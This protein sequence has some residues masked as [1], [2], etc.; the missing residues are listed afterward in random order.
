[1]GTNGLTP[2]DSN[3]SVGNNQYVETVN[4]RYQIWSLNRA[5]QHTDLPAGTGLDQHPVGGVRRALP[6]TERGDPSSSMT[7]WRTAGSSRSS[8]PRFPP[9]STTSAW[10]SPPPRTRPGLTSGGP[11]PCRGACSATTRTSGPGRT[12]TT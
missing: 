2:S 4:T 11:S 10:R 5:H 9:A 8:P 1:V 7:R 6:G 3:G 12:R